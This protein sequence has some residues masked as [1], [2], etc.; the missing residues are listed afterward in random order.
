MSMNMG[1]FNAP[2]LTRQIG[3]CEIC[4]FSPAGLK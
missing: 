1:C 4:C 2:C 3:A